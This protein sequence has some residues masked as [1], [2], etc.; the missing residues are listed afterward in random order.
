MGADDEIQAD[1]LNPQMTEPKT[2]EQK[3]TENEREADMIRLYDTLQYVRAPASATRGDQGRLNRPVCHGSGSCWDCW[4]AAICPV[5]GM[6]RFILG[7]Y[8]DDWRKLENARAALE[9]KDENP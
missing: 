3:E 9:G 4:N 7:I 1:I 5:F 6:I 8:D 2:A